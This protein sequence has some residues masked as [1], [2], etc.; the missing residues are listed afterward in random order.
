MT[1]LISTAI[2]CDSV[3]TLYVGC[4]CL[5]FLLC[6]VASGITHHFGCVVVALTRF[7]GA[8]LSLNILGVLA[9]Q[10]GEFR[11][12]ITLA[13]RAVTANTGGDTAVRVTTTVDFLAKL[14]QRLLGSTDLHR[15]G[16]IKCCQIGNIL[17]GQG[18]SH[19]RHGRVLAFTRLECL[20]LHRNV[21]G[22]LTGQIRPIRVGTIAI[23]PVT[24]RASR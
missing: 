2:S 4:H 1:A 5:D 3:Q 24:T 20:E 18:G 7:K 16:G 21:G 14:N 11:C 17:F 19:R 12:R 8:Q 10:S 22:S 15:L 23:H 6:H 9:A 13:A